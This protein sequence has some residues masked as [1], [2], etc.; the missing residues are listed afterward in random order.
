MA[1]ENVLLHPLR[2]ENH[3]MARNCLEK[4]KR[5]AKALGLEKEKTLF[6]VI[7]TLL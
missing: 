4:K 1:K 7:K 6:N 2:L 3:R 5:K